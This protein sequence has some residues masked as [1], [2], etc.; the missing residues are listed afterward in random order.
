MSHKVYPNKNTSLNVT[1]LQWAS[2]QTNRTL[3]WTS[4]ATEIPA[5][6]SLKGLTI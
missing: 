4:L 2:S 6:L 3:P 5:D 1:A